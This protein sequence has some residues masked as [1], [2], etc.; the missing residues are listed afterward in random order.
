MSVDKIYGIHAQALTLQQSRLSAIA[1]NIANVDT[2]N[3]Q[4][5]DID[6]A[7][8]LADAAG[9]STSNAAAGPQRTHARHLSLNASTAGASPAP[10][11]ATQPSADGNTVEL[12]REQAAF[13]DAAL[14]YRA[15]VQFAQSRIS[16]LMTAIKGQ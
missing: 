14:R 10:R 5:R 12:H 9:P 4:A 13:A 2:P 15:S 16:G 3:Y 1:G 8:V 11:E 7:S 6:F